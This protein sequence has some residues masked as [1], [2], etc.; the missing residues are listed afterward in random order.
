MMKNV[1]IIKVIHNIVK[2]IS[3]FKYKVI[4]E[5]KVI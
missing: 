3:A 5:F 4:V 1:K 2:V